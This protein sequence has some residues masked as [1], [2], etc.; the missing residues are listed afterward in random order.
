M[1]TGELIWMLVGF[2]LTLLILS[3]V[4]GDN[5]LFRFAAYL[6]VG[7]AAGYVLVM[8]VDQLLLPRL[9][10]PMMTGGEQSLLLV[11]P[12]VLGVLLFLRLSPRLAGPGSISM[13]FLVGVGAAVV[14]GG[15]VFGTLMGQTRAAVGM[16]NFNT[17]AALKASPVGGLLE[18]LIF[19]IG[20]VCTLA[21]F[22]FGASAKPG[23]PVARP[24][25]IE[26]LSRVGQAF[27]AITL[28]ALFAGVYASA[29]TALVDRISFI[30]A[31]VRNLAGMAGR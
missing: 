24:R 28:G 13:A 31:V 22:H 4:L 9:I 14:V 7:V 30:E 23:Q 15:V 5:P 25:L 16:L 27:I 21:Y 2:F 8:V 26:T 1:E 10:R 29:V 17:S 12:L 6:F 18:G 19:L 20:T 3:Y 11:V